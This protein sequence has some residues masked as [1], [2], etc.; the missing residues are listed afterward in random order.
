MDGLYI[1]LIFVFTSVELFL[2]QGLRLPLPKDI[3]GE[4]IG[5]V[6]VYIREDGARYRRSADGVTV[7]AKNME[8]VFT[9]NESLVD[10]HLKRNEEISAN[11]PIYTMNRQG[12]V[13]AEHIQDRN[14]VF[15]YQDEQRFAAFYVETAGSSNCL[16]G[17]FEDHNNEFFLEPKDLDCMESTNNN[18][19][20]FRVLKI[21]HEGFQYSDNIKMENRTYQPST[22]ENGYLDVKR[23][24]A[25]YKI[26]MLL[27]IDY[28]IYNYWFTQS[29]GSSTAA[30]DTDAKY[31]IRQYY[32][33]VIN[34]M[35]VRYKNIQSS[36][37]TIS[38]LFGGIFIADTVEKSSFTEPFKD[39]SSPRPG[40]EASPVLNNVT[41]W[42]QN[43]AGLPAHDH[44]MMFTRYDL[45]SQGSSSTK[46]LAW[47]AVV[48][49][50]QSVSIVEDDFNFVI[51]TVAAH[52]LG[53]SLSASH[54]GDGNGCSGNDAYIM[55]AS[56]GVPVNTNPWKF[57]T[58]SIN[59]FTTYIASLISK[60]SNC[61]TSLSSNFDPTA[62]KQFTSLP[63]QVYDVD[64]LCKHL[65]GPQSSFCKFPYKGDYTTLCLSLW[66]YKT[67]G[68][69]GCSGFTGVDGLQCGNKKRCQTG[70]CT[71][72]VC[73]PQK[74]ESCLFGDDTGTVVT[75]NTGVTKTCADVPSEPSLCYYESVHKGCC[76]TCPRYH[77]GR[78]GCEYG[79]RVSGC[80]SG[81]CPKYKDTQC[82]GLCYSGP[83]ITTTTV[84]AEDTNPCQNYTLKTS[85]AAT[86]T[87]ITDSPISN[88]SSTANTKTMSSTST[89]KT[90]M[91]TISNEVTFKFVLRM[92]IIVAED[93]S[94]ST[95]Y[96]IVKDKA[97]YA[98]TDLYRKRLGNSFKSCSV[99]N[100]RKGSLVVDYRV[101]TKN[102]PS[103]TENMLSINQ[104]ILTG[105]ANVTYDGKDAP[106]SS[107]S[108]FDSSGKAVNL[109]STTTACALLEAS[110]PC[111]SGSECVEE[112][113][114]P[115]CRFTTDDG[116]NYWCC[117]SVRCHSGCY[118]VLRV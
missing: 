57:S 56:V 91:I 96:Y 8:I 14:N 13:E 108:F 76:Q 7:P 20:V 50:S 37:Y 35:D 51:L 61:M 72:D 74:D 62:L 70:V 86:F 69:G 94:N 84:Q 16:F 98:L 2:T 34:G 29:T 39:S 48:C 64:A 93:L 102:S 23:S 5:E 27:I 97:Q 19:S 52:E 45:K 73:A 60:G 75:F 90:T 92:D 24:V 99:T 54:D 31:N 53:H 77:T 78:A 49:E 115:V 9:L 33:W 112:G 85:T 105:K 36:A 26:E 111:Q 11:V 55:A 18:Q 101:F 28:S 30:K 67:D 1:L 110:K 106:V 63:G 104:D 17:S 15:F 4:E 118:H 25:E 6:V 88:I 100:L 116:G 82:C 21:K 42:V 79:D 58:C 80:T 89:D 12:T 46:G 22:D 65:M 87:G 44:A 43:T 47:V 103:A 95:Q 10:L 41:K 71:Y 66:C 81:H 114:G 109:T 113:N 117:N 38:I 107:M 68:S 83:V 3:E 32:A 40:V 59:Y